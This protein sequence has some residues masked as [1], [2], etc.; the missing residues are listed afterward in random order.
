MCVCA[1]CISAASRLHLGCTSGR[2]GRHA[3]YGTPWDSATPLVL[4]GDRGEITG[5]PAAAW[6]WAFWERAH[7][8]HFVTCK[9]RAP[10]FDEDQSADT[11]MC[12]CTL[13]EAMAYARTAHLSAAPAAGQAP[14]LYMNGWDVFDAIP[15]LWDDAIDQLPGSTAPLTVSEYRRL[16]ALFKLDT[17]D[18]ARR[19]A[20]TRAPVTL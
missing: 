1:C 17:T 11:L 15:A 8:H 20:P 4:T 5:W 18:E 13:R 6:G 7:G 10:L 2:C 16:N 14:L 9:Q 12:E 19:G 3:P